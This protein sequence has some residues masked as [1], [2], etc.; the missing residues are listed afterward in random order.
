MF[1]KQKRTASKGYTFPRLC[2]A[3]EETDGCA[4]CTVAQRESE[5]TLKMLFH[6]GIMES[7]LRKR[8]L[9]GS[10]FCNWHTWMSI[11]DIPTAAAG[12]AIVYREL[13]EAVITATAEAA[14]SLTPTQRTLL[15]RRNRGK[16]RLAGAK[17]RCAVCESVHKTENVY[18]NDLLE[19]FDDP[20]L[21]SRFAR[22][23][24]L[25]L[26][27]LQMA[28][29]EFPNHSN[30]LR[31]LEVE[32]EK[33]SALEGELTEFHRKRDYRFAHEPAGREYTSWRRALEL[34][35]GKRGVFPRQE[36]RR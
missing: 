22:S 16:C 30:L 24:G 4:L 20:Q 5:H 6:E 19:F 18:L 29:D 15:S 9:D 10:G 3:L 26:P 35:A 8:L 1:K 2:D 17:R 33:F 28:V 23:V 7:S 27:H 11:N 34:F 32:R 36:A 13:L 31:L 12:T 25:C 21:Q 14:K